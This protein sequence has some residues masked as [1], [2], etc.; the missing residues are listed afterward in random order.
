MLEPCV[1]HLCPTDIQMLEICE[2]TQMMETRVGN[3][4]SAEVEEFELPE[5]RHM[6]QVRIIDFRVSQTQLPEFRQSTQRLQPV[7]TKP[8]VIEED[9]IDLLE[10][11]RIFLTQM[12]GDRIVQPF[13]SRH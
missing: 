6:P 11:P 10:S 13:R 5:P 3:L 4:R 9:S 2:F 12:F 1:C 7:V 8:P